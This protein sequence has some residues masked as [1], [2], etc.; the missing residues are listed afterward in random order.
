MKSTYLVVKLDKL[1]EALAMSRGVPHSPSVEALRVLVHHNGRCL[2]ELFSG[3]RLGTLSLLEAIP[4]ES[5]DVYRLCSSGHVQ[6]AHRVL[7]YFSLLIQPVNRR[8]DVICE[9]NHCVGLCLYDSLLVLLRGRH[10][11][12]GD[13]LRH[14]SSPVVRL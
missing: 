6:D 9:G 8:Q 5:F 13:C 11:K 4:H 2:L 7:L 14:L 1:D 10:L 12:R 3:R